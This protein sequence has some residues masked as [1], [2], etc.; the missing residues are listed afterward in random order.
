MSSYPISRVLILGASGQF[1][2]RLCRRLVQVHGLH[3][4]LGGRDRQKLEAT[5]RQLLAAKLG[6]KID[7]LAGKINGSGLLDLLRSRRVNLVVHLAGPFQGQDYAI[8][9]A[10]L[11]AG[12]PYIDMADGREF[13]AKFSSLDSTAQ[14]KGIPLITG[15]STVPGLSSAIIDGV[16]GHFSQLQTIDYGIC[17]GVK[18]GLGLATLKAVLS[19]C[20]KPYRVLKDGRFVTI[21]GLGSPRHHDFPTPVSR[22]YVVDCDIPDHDL[23]PA[24]YTALRQIDFGSCIDVPGLPRL[25]SLMSACVRK[26]W[27]ED[28]N[29]LSAIIQPCLKAVKFVGSPHSGFFMRLEGQDRRGNP[30]KMLFEIVARDGSGLEIPVTPVI[31]LIKKMLRGDSLPAGA[32]PCMGLFSLA[33]FQQE[34]SSYPISWESKDVQ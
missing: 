16:I 25:L 32:Y 19:Y 8:A 34:L 23:F 22:R 26:G 9:R 10:C 15:A 5:S 13:V 1:G 31:L 29:F 14:S 17:A 3:L 30:K 12:V 27:I 20:G 24:S 4:F 18:S 7:I 6:A 21:F 2:S 11:Q 28:W 33:E